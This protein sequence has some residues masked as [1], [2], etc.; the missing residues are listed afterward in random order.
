MGLVQIAPAARIRDEVVEAEEDADPEDRDGEEEVRAHRDGAERGRA[1][2]PDEHRV[3][4][5]HRHPAD[6]G[7]RD[8]ARERDQRLELRSERTERREP[9][10]ALR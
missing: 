1:D 6:L 5:A 10:H 8:R 3:D 9:A 2:P 4:E 7:E